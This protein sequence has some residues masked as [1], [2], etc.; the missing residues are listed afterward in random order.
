MKIIKC[1]HCQKEFDISDSEYADILSQVNKQE[2]ED[3]VKKS[4]KDNQEKLEAHIEQLK[5]EK[6][7]EI[8]KLQHDFEVKKQQLENEIKNAS[9]DKDDEILALKN[10]IKLNEKQKDIDLNN[11]KNEYEAKL[12]QAQETIA[13]YSDLKSKTSVKLLGENLEQHCQNA[14]NQYRAT[15]FPNAYFEKDNEVSKESDSKGDYIFRDKANDIEYLSIMFDMKNE[16]D[17]TAT[18][19]TNESFLKELDKDRREKKCEYAVL[20][21]LLEPDNDFYNAGIVDVSYRYPKMYV[22]RPQCFISIITLL[23]NAAKNSLGYQQQLQEI[24]RRDVDIE[25][26]ETNLENFKAGALRNY[27]LAN[28]KF[29]D[30]IKQIDATIAKLQKVR[31]DLVGSENNFRLLNDKAQDLTIKQL[32]KDSPSLQ[33]Q[34]KK[35]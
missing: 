9:K 19:Q 2:I 17:K 13:Y 3:Q 23:M 34:I 14:F 32:A 35:K 11:T 20:V 15:L 33:A 8:V 28:E 7:L 24:K 22:V 10:T 5:L 6:E 30:A 25:N 1:P 21:S 12:K 16:A 29:T 27:R 26:F 18:K 31:E 4:E